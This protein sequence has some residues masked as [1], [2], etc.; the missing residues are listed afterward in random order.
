MNNYNQVVATYKESL[1]AWRLDTNVVSS[2]KQEIV[3][4]KVDIGKENPLYFDNLKKAY[5]DL[6]TKYEHLLQR[7]KAY[8][9]KQK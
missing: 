3:N 4:E 1:N 9:L 8:K 5:D 2:I 6:N 7:R